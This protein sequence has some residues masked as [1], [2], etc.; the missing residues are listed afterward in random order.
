MERLTAIRKLTM[1]CWHLRNMLLPLLWEYV[2]GCNLLGR[3][4]IRH[5]PGSD[6]MVS[7]KNGLYDQC[8]YLI[9]NPT[10]CPYVQYVYSCIHSKKN[11]QGVNCRA[12][13]VDLSFVGPIEELIKVFVDCL[14]RL[15]NLRSLEVFCPN[16]TS[17]FTEELERARAQF[18]SIRNLGVCRVSVPVRSC[19]N[20]ESV[21]LAGGY[22]TD[23]QMACS[24]GKQ[25]RRIAGIYK[26]DLWRGEFRDAFPS[27]VPNRI[28][29]VAEGCP[30]LREI[31]I[32]GTTASS[33]APV[34]V[35]LQFQ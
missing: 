13:S 10:I 30:D 2:E 1:T 14:V 22:F 3:A 16:H 18:P 15:P 34:V 31:S 26:Q 21:T 17:P 6:Q 19:P 24:Y 20:V 23:I 8:W 29:Q 4:T 27:E 12:L 5:H 32:K 28:M 9:L 11:P 7:L 25:L 33:R 35:S